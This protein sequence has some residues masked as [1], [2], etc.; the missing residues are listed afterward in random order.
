MTTFGKVQKIYELRS[1]GYNDLFTELRNIRNEL[2]AIRAAKKAI[3]NTRF[4]PGQ[5]EEIQKA[6]KAVAE[7]R[8]KEAELKVERQKLINDA[9]A[10]QAQRQAEITQREKGRQSIEDEKLAQ[11]QLRTEREKA[12]LQLKQDQLQ[13]QQEIDQRRRERQANSGVAG[14]VGEIAKQ[15]QE[16]HKIVRNGT[17]VGDDVS[18]RG[19]LL[20]Y[21][22]AIAKLKELA[23]AEQDFRRQFSKD[24]LL[25]GEYT[26][27]IVQAF[28]KMGLDDLISGQITRSQ[29]RLTD[30]NGNFE[31]LRQELVQLQVTGQGS[32][33]AIERGMIE[34]RNEAIQLEGQIGQLQHELRGF[35]DIGNQITA[36]IRN[37][38]RELRTQVG[39]LILSYFGIQA[40]ISG[41]QESVST[42]KE[43]A[44]STTN[45]EIELNKVVGGVDNLVDSL[46]NLNTRTKLTTLEDIANI[47][48]RAGTAEE[49]LLGV[50]EAI[51]KTKVAFGKD[52][53]DI[54]SGTETFAKLINIFYEDRQITGDRI[55]RIGNSVR[56]L[57]NETVASVPYIND[58]AGRMAGLRQI[59]K[60]TLPDVIG[61][62]AGFEE[63]KQSAETSS[64]ALVKI[65]PKLATDVAKYAEIVRMPIE[66]FRELLNQNP[67]EALI[68]VAESL[69]RTGSGVE[70]V[71]AALGDAELGAGRVTTILGTLGGKADVFRDR[72]NRAKQ[73]INETT[74]IEDAFARKN[75]NLAATLDKIGKKFSDAAGS[76]AFQSTL[77]V[78][79]SIVLFFL[80]NLP[81]FITLLTA[82]TVT[83]GLA[84][85]EL[86]RA[87]VV[88]FALTLATQAQAAA[89]TVS[90]IVMGAY[91]TMLALYT[92]I[93]T[94][95]AAATGL[96]SLAL[97]ALPFGIILTILGILIASYH[98]FA[99]SVNGSTETLRKQALQGRILTEVNDKINDSISKQVANLDALRRIL[100]SNTASLDTRKKALEDMIAIDNRFADVMD[101]QIISLTKLDRAYRDV[102]ESIK[103]KAQAEAAGQLTQEKNKD[104]LNIATIRQ[105]IERDSIIQGNETFKVFNGF[106]EEDMKMVR[107][108]IRD[109]GL[110]IY[111][112]KTSFS[113]TDE[114]LQPLLEGLKE[115]ES[116]ATDVYIEYSDFLAKKQQ[117]INDKENARMTKQQQ[118]LAQRAGLSEAAIGEMK[119]LIK[120]IDDQIEKLVPSDPKVQELVKQKNDLQ[121]QIDKALGTDKTSSSG[122]RLSGNQR[123]D[124]KDIDADRDDALSAQNLLFT[125][126]LLEESKYLQEILRINQDAIDKKL[127]KLKGANAEE[128]KIIAD[129]KSDRITQERDTNEKLFKLEED[130]L[131]S[132][133][134]TATKNADQAAKAVEDNPIATDGEKAQA[135]LDADKAILAAQVAF[136]TGMDTLEKRLSMISK[137]NAE[138]R[139]TAMTKVTNDVNKDLLALSRSHISDM[140]KQSDKEI[141][142][143]K[144]SIAQQRAAIL[145]NNKL[146]SFQKADL[147]KKL[148]QTENIGVLAREVDSMTKMLPVYKQLLDDKK[149]TDQEYNEFLTE[150]YEKQAQLFQSTTDAQKSQIKG[151]SDAVKAAIATLFK[152]SDDMAGVIYTGLAGAYDLAKGAMNNFYDAERN[153]IEESKSA[154]LD[155]LDLE[156]KRML[157]FASSKEEEEQIEKKFDQKKK[158]IEKEAGNRLRDV[159]KKEA[160]L[161][162]VTELANIAAAAAAN[163]YNGVT[164]GAAGVA[165]YAIM[166]ALALG[167][168]ALRV[169]EINNTQFAYGGSPD[170]VPTRGGEFGGNDH[171]NGGTPFVYKG[172]TFEAEVDELA[173]IR[174]RNAATGNYTISGNHTQIA[175]ALNEI[176]GGVRFAP[177]AAVSKYEYGGGLGESLRPPVFVPAAYGPVVSSSSSVQSEKTLEAIIETAK[178][179]QAVSDR[180]DRIEVVQ[181]T[182]TVTD[183]QSKLVKQTKIG[184]VL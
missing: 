94:R 77:I 3:G 44:D 137:K 38:F 141:S 1:L 134:E 124:M 162:F 106:S 102:I 53:G 24:G 40:I 52:F 165:Q 161:A 136:N 101:S 33:E 99:A 127:A 46:G 126:G 129:L 179:I 45:L 144:A 117:E 109:R 60:I 64:T 97:R 131:R 166:S 32:L 11:Q 86:I 93:T 49:N 14:S 176:G 181:D 110:R 29:Q 151:F 139:A 159:K 9:K 68:L 79:S 170:D 133:L 80:A 16:L 83:W 132:Q 69:V 153:R 18:F 171:S 89:I 74:A 120:N 103:L 65:I 6:A 39:Q 58:F 72:I 156:K 178:G 174:T 122:S 175:S 31:S 155:K 37:G 42:A 7:L 184:S 19:E 35:G 47:S 48:L 2:D 163:V 73:A 13:R 27:G 149:I 168:Y 25:V 118:D 182:R 145:A 50:T 114:E 130:R 128:R 180:I 43:L 167:R 26:S 100:L 183:A 20:T 108:I 90:T 28:K 142:A 116:Q 111:S 119:Q 8:V 4:M 172:R 152:V 154:A 143:Y 56:T 177:G 54:E 123:D 157:S 21:D 164:F 160:R 158:Q 76:R 140:Q 57:A 150:L 5:T 34:N 71:A 104:V 87:R 85:T 173:V 88:S 61:L 70:E 55:L 84:N 75:E 67:A 91:N 17:A 98:A 96:L 41:M 62:G 10:Q 23:A 81:L 135:K 121:A 15:F 82:W 107:D 147:N 59:T 63:F 36:S 113:S 92:G 115:R 125:K 51:D 169:G 95:A 112:A 12:S 22:Q 66:Q 148:D 105:R 78:L 138:E 30:L 146:S